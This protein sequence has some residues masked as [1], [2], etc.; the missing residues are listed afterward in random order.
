MKPSRGTYCIM[1]GGSIDIKGYGRIH[2]GRGKYV[3]AHRVIYVGVHGPIPDSLVIDHLCRNP[4]CVN[5]QHLE[6]VT[7]QVNILR[8]T[9]VAAVNARKTHCIHGHEFNKKNTGVMTTTGERYCKRCHKQRDGG[10]HNRG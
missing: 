5:P 10:R 9:G 6:A 2:V 4:A 3:K 7:S 1:W 8:G